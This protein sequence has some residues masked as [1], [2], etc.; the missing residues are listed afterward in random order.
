EIMSKMRG[1]AVAVIRAMEPSLRVEIA[2]VKRL[3]A[4]KSLLGQ[5]LNRLASS[6]SDYSLIS[7]EVKHRTEQL[8]AA[9]AAL[10]EAQSSRDAS[11]AIDFVSRVGDVRVGNNPEGPGNS[12]ILLGSGMAGCLFGLGITFLI[13]P[14]PHQPRYGRRQS[15]V[16]RRASDRDGRDSTRVIPETS[17]LPDSRR[18]ADSVFE[19]QRQSDAQSPPDSQDPPKRRAADRATHDRRAT[20]RVTHDR[21]ATDNAD[22]ITLPENGSED[23]TTEPDTAVESHPEMGPQEISDDSDSPV[24]TED[25]ESPADDD[26]PKWQQSPS[27]SPGVQQTDI[28]PIP[29]LPTLGTEIKWSSPNSNQQ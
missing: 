10:A 16:G 24:P 22:V 14:S 2:R 28:S 5:R 21:R 13:A 1:E 23:S 18:D 27:A 3:R 7:A 17:P 29:G 11:Q 8:E 20:D 9:D 19:M 15:D 25:P 6:R 26:E 12:M 4:K